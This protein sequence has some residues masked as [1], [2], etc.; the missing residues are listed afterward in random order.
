MSA[1]RRLAA[2][3]AAGLA[4]GA[5]L[6]GIGC[7]KAVD[8]A[9][10]VA[11]AAGLQQ[12]ETDLLGRRGS[13]QRERSQIT[14]A[15]RELSDKRT[16]LGH[17]NPAQA[18]LDEEE[19]KLT[20]KELELTGEESAINA[21]L[22]ELLKARAELVQKASVA[23]Q[24]GA[25]AD[26]LERAAHREQGVAEREKALARREAD[27]AE[28]EKGVADREAK[29]AKREKETCGGALMAVAPIG[30][31]E[32]PKS[33]KYSAHDVE[34]VY[35]KALK[36]MHDRGILT[37]D[38]PPGS[39]KLVEETR[40]AMKAAD[41]MRAKYSADQLLATVEQIK[42][43]RNFITTK[44][45]R[46]ASS[47]RGKKLEKSVEGLFQDATANY[48]DGRFQDANQKINKLF[49]QLR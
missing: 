30:K 43:D 7:K 13:L 31:V 49:E 21:K 12:H 9:P 41:F 15:R 32:P 18:A 26:P 39:S 25:A 19:K 10:I 47:M 8:T 6:A 20:Q 35:K 27:V 34:P 48:G 40:E 38:L 14:E 24:G 42:I 46:L 2:G 29:Q 28:R 3:L 5:V 1:H 11:E 44:M 4:L 23:V 17:D 33:G 36:L 45:A 16:Q 37:A 22:D